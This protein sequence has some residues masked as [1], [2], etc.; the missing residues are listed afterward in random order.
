M[1]SGSGMSTLLNNVDEIVT[2]GMGWMGDAV[3]EVTKSGNELLLLFC[4][5]GF[6]GTGIGLMKRLIG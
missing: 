4:V 6:I 3:T 2:S 5:I 1:G